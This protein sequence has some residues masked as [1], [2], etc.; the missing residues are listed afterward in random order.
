MSGYIGKSDCQQC[1]REVDVYENRAGMAYYNC[2][3]CGVRVQ[4]RTQ[5]G[6]ASFMH[7][8]RREVEPE[9]PASKTPENPAPP[10]PEKSPEKPAKRGLM[11]NTIFGG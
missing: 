1:G 6:H 7:G 9:A 5:R 2:G 4:Q 11:R 3:P 10:A 8:V